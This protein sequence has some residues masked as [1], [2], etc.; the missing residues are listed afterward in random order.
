MFAYGAAAGG[1]P[2]HQPHFGVTIATCARGELRASPDGVTVYGEAGRREVGIAQ[3]PRW[4]GR[5]NVLDDLWAAIRADRKPVHYGNW[6]KATLEVA[7]A[8]QA[9]AR[10]GREITLKHQVGV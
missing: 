2:P 4:I 5:G 6:G 9:S 10:E 8:I 3:G 1:E 7:L